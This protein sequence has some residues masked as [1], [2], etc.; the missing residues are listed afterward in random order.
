MQD[1]NYV[2]NAIA[3][4]APAISLVFFCVF[5]WKH[6]SLIGFI[7]ISIE[8]HKWT[9]DFSV[10][11]RQERGKFAIWM[12]WDRMGWDGMTKKWFQTVQ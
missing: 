5:V 11:G 2:Q 3:Q 12:G 6:G 4:F 10:T 7:T 8:I 9:I 1:T